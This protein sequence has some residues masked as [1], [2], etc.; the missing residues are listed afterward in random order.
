ME[1]RLKQAPK[2]R[3]HPLLDEPLLVLPEGFAKLL[4]SL[5]VAPADR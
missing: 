4:D 3:I 1:N 2:Q 5:R